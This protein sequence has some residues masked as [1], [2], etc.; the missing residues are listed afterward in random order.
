MTLAIVKLLPDPVMPSSVWNR[1]PFSKPRPSASMA[2]G[3]SP[4]GSMGVTNS[5]SGT[6]FERTGGVRQ[7]RPRFGFAFAFARR[8]PVS[9]GRDLLGRHSLQ[10]VPDLVDLAIEL[11]EVAGV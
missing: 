1:S 3:W 2:S 10:L 4:A 5:N 9:V 11:V 7:L 8:I 6:G